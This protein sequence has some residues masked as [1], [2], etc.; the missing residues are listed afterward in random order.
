MAYMDSG[1]QQPRR[2]AVYGRQ[3]KDNAD[4]IDRQVR[5]CTALIEAR[6]WTLVDTYVDDDTSASKPRGKGTR[7]AAMLADAEA[8]RV[9][10][11]VAVDLDRLLRSTRDLNTLIDAGLMAVT[12]DGEIDLSTADG[13]FRAT[14]LAGIAR[15]EVRRKGERQ[16][17]ANEQM[18]ER[19]QPIYRGR[20]F[21]YQHGNKKLDETE[22]RLIREAY[23]A[24]MNGGSQSGVAREWTRIGARTER[25]G[26]WNAQRVRQV[27]SNPVY[28]G[29]GTYR[30]QLTGVKGDWEAIF[31]EDEWR[32]FMA[33]TDKRRTGPRT[34]KTVASLLTGL[35]RCGRCEAVG[36]DVTV[37]AGRNNRN[38]P[39]YRCPTHPHLARGR[40]PIDALVVETIVERLSRPDAV[41]LVED[42]ERVERLREVRG[43]AAV[44]RA[45][46]DEI[47]VLFGDGDMTPAQFKAASNTARE[48]LTALE[49]QQVTLTG[50]NVL[51]GLVGAPDVRAAWDALDVDRQ[52]AIV[53][54]LLHVTINP[55]GPGNRRTFQ[56]ET[57]TLVWRDGEDA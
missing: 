40:A 43:Q 57:I 13:E 37:V 11:V 28:A 17:R 18:A 23:D 19:G 15:F 52:R 53:A 38:T 7:W 48:K 3:S 21:G 54:R 8:G 4:G 50:G 9:D 44:V 42:T 56:P 14:M 35:A 47:A 22:A 6:G 46:L 45:R 55:T 5:R 26:Q 31:T 34:G 41:A 39:T 10:L 24:I 2:A 33:V 20:R 12:V 27:L 25:G 30:R 1:S 49:A 32:A 36:E 51:A 29:M 16:R